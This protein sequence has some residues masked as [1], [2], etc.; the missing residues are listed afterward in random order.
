MSELFEGADLISGYSRREALADGVLVDLSSHPELGPLVKE[1]GLR[2]PLAMTA[3][4]FGRYVALTP[5]AERA[6]NDLR[7]RAWDVLYMLSRA[8]RR[9]LAR[10]SDGDTVLFDFLCVVDQ[11]Q[12]VL[13]RLKAVIG[14]DD[15][16]RPCFTVLLPDED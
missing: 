7:G 12:P 6:G 8:I 9:E 11:S 10:G 13:S 3:A 15:D 14:P 5:A 1:A 16:G 2:F 4:A